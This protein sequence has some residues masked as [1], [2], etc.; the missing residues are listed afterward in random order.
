MATPEGHPGRRAAAGLSVR[1]NTVLVQALGTL[2]LGQHVPSEL[3][4]AV[5]EALVWAY[6]LTETRPPA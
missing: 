3:Y 5:A 4:A 1:D 6:G 2:D